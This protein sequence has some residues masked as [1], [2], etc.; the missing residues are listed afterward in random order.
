MQKILIFAAALWLTACTNAGKDTTNTVAAKDT[1]KTTVDTTKVAA[2]VVDSP[3]VASNTND[4]LDDELY[5]DLS[6]PAT[7]TGTFD[8]AV[9]YAGKTDF[10][11]EIN[12]KRKLIPITFEDYDKIENGKKVA[13]YDVPANLIDPSDDLEGVPG[14]NP[15]CIGKKYTIS[16]SKDLIS[17]KP[18]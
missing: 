17:I 15:K 7:Y 2:T 13:G 12:G 18:M 9:V 10:A 6:T 1:A 3:K 4:E 16:I 14:G 5:L 8:D 11:F